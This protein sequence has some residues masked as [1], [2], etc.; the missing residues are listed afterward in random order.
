M[1]S[2]ATSLSAVI[3]TNKL[4]VH[5][6]VDTVPSHWVYNLLWG[7]SG[8]LDGLAA[9]AA[10]L[11]L[12][13]SG[14]TSGWFL[15]QVVLGIPWRMCCPCRTNCST[16]RNGVVWKRCWVYRRGGPHLLILGNLH[17]SMGQLRVLWKRGLASKPVI[18]NLLFTDSLI[19]SGIVMPWK[20]VSSRRKGAVLQ[21]GSQQIL[22]SWGFAFW[23]Y[24]LMSPHPKSS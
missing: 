7:C 22:L 16:T 3:N 12:Q 2:T 6:H 24:P 23:W 11:S 4:H 15:T 20:C 19:W 17:S 10:A 5:A 8:Y 14:W 9:R 1:K 13:T 18:T 21:A